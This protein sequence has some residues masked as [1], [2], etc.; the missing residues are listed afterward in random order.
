M[1]RLLLHHFYGDAEAER[2]DKLRA[3]AYLAFHLDSAVHHVDN[4]FGD[5]K[6]QAGTLNAAYRRSLFALERLE[7]VLQEFGG[8]MP[9]PCLL[10]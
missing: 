7:H 8:L 10:R 4:V 6:V 5:G 9:M 3:L 1:R 2:N